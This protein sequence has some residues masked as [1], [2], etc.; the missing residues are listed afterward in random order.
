MYED[1]EASKTIIDHLGRKA[2]IMRV[3]LVSILKAINLLLRNRANGFV[4]QW[5]H[6]HKL[7]LPSFPNIHNKPMPR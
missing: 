5:S 2:L 1:Y 6:Q 4:S 3:L 7:S